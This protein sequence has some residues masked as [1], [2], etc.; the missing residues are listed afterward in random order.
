M[1]KRKQ[2]DA[3]RFLLRLRC[4]EY[5]QL[6]VMHRAPR[7]SRPDKARR[8][9]YKAKQH[10]RHHTYNAPNKVWSAYQLRVSLS[11]AFVF[12]AVAA[13]ALTGR[14]LSTVSPCTRE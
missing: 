14:V 10:S 6:P 13:S 11:T 1:H 3:M 4:W 8:L 12:A 5:R 9:G 7:S 2:C